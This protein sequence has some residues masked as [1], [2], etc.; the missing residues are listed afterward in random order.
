[1]GDANSIENVRQATE[2]LNAA[3]GTFANRRMDASIRKAL[4]GKQ[5]ESLTL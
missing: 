2:A 5:I 3:T 4:S 1:M